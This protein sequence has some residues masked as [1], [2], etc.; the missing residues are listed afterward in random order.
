M[1]D[2][3]SPDAPRRRLLELRA[4]PEWDRTD[5]Q[6]DELNE[7]EIQF[8]PG[9]RI[10]GPSPERNS[11]PSTALRSRSVWNGRRGKSN[12]ARTPFSNPKPTAALK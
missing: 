3:S 6:W 4:L 8:A 2:F 12:A 5:A 7:L 10:A 1:N 9:N 11:A